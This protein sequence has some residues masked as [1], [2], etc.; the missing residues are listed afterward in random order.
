MPCDCK[1][2]CG[3]N[4]GCCMTIPND[5]KYQG[6]CLD[7]ANTPALCAYQGSGDR[8]DWITKWCPS[9][10]PTPPPGPAPTPTPP[11]GPGPSPTPHGPSPSPGP[12]PQPSPGSPSPSKGLS[13]GAIIGIIVGGCI[14]LGIIIALALHKNKK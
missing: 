11:P 13:T 12:G 10:S 2:I 7:F 6:G 3:P 8:T 5:P 9:S 14:V 1:K 4:G